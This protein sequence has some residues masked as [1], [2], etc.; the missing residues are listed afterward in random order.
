MTGCRRVPPADVEPFTGLRFVRIEAGQFTMGS[1]QTEPG[2]RPEE[3][4]HRVTITHAFSMSTTEVTQRQW[5]RVMGSNPSHFKGNPD[6]PVERVTWNDV[7][8]F[9]RRLNARGKGTYRLPTE[10]E[11]EYACRAGSERAY[12]F[13]AR[14]SSSQANY[15][16]RYPLPGQA[17]GIYRGKTTPVGTF[18]RNAWGVYDMHGNVWE[19]CEDDYC[20]Y[21]PQATDP[22]A[23]CGGQLQVIRG[24]SWY[25][26]ADSARG[27]LRY[28]HARDLK[29]FSIG[30]RVVKTL[31]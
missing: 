17:P 1:P 11:W 6:Q 16:A 14:L 9:L 22:L 23:R 8:E 4:Q 26:N 2:H 5:M 15:D 24:G 30:F 27:A 21:P 10:A 18:E 7:H 29:G 28:T 31:D 13:G 19:W 12:A 20:P 25:F 3:T